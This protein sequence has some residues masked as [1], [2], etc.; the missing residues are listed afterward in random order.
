[1]ALLPSLPSVTLT[2]AGQCSFTSLHQPPPLPCI[3]VLGQ[4]LL[5]LWSSILFS[6][7]PVALWPPCVMWQNIF[8]SVFFC[9]LPWNWSPVCL[10]DLGP[11]L[12][13][14][15]LPQIRCGY[16]LEPCWMWTLDWRDHAVLL[17]R[18]FLYSVLWAGSC[19]GRLMEGQCASTLSLS[20]SA[21]LLSW[22]HS[23][24][25]LQT[26]YLLFRRQASTGF[27]TCLL[28]GDLGFSLVRGTFDHLQH[29]LSEI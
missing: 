3:T 24:P 6:W 10:Q 5:R 17:H 22:E 16:G 7:Q 2:P 15:S 14:I 12:E 27:W 26:A 8:P 9:S 23:V 13:W 25:K 19:T 21:F 29:H 28:P 4:V 20:T 11:S 1:M 18:P